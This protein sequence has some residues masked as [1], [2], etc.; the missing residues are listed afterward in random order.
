LSCTFTDNSSDRDGSIVLWQWS[1]GDAVSSSV[2]NPTH[3]YLAGGTYP[4]TL[5]V[6]DNSGTS[7]TITN[8]VTVAPP[9][10]PPPVP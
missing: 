1:F 5:T 9:D 3:A 4:V 7:R 2:Q 8:S 6:N 10:P